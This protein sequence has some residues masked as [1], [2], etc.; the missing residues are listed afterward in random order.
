MALAT[1]FI[2]T[3]RILRKHPWMSLAVISALVLGVG[4]S[5]AVYA[6]INAVVL[7]PL[8]VFEPTRVVRMYAKVNTTG[9]T[10]GISYPEYLD[11]KAECHSFQAI[12]VM[13]ALSFYSADPEH[14]AHIKGMG[15]SASGFNV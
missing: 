10:M 5:T 15:I 6:I 9:A 1:D 7:R 3:W 14:P 2:F 13:R 12:S 4:A 8:P 11:L